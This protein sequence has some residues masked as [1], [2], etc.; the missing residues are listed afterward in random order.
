MKNIA[1]RC[2][3]FQLINYFYFILSVSK[4]NK[5]K[6]AMD[7]VKCETCGYRYKKSCYKSHNKN[8]IHLI[9]IQ[10]KLKVNN[11]DKMDLLIFIH[12]KIKNTNNISNVKNI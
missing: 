12:N 1:K 3:V 8:M 4:Y 6:H 2:P 5:L 7:L 11:N 10:E 9:G